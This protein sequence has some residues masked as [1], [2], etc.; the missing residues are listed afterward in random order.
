VRETLWQYKK[1]HH[2]RAGCTGA[3]GPILLSVVPLDAYAMLFALCVAVAELDVVAACGAAFAA[4]VA[5]V[6]LPLYLFVSWRAAVARARDA[7][8][9][10]SAGDAS[11][12]FGYDTRSIVVLAGAGDIPALPPCSTPMR[13]LA[14]RQ[15]AGGEYR[16]GMDPYVEACRRRTRST[17][18]RARG[19][20]GR[21]FPSRYVV[22]SLRNFCVCVCV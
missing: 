10:R 17:P 9:L 16:T 15:G 19:G 14:K 4:T 21:H 12:A 6:T 11:L 18:A 7:E 1:D 20:G 2:T 13:A 5:C 8:S 22:R 3:V